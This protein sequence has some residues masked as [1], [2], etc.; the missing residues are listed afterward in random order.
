MNT[1]TL[2]EY[3]V[4][5]GWDIHESDYKHA[6]DVI[7]K[8]GSQIANKISP[9]VKTLG[10]AASF[11]LDVLKVGNKIIEQTIS[12]VADLD[13]ETEKLA[14]QWWVSEEAARSYSTALDALGET[15]EDLATMTDEQYRRLV[16]LNQ[17]G[18]S[19]EAPK[20]LDDFLLI[21]R[22]IKLE[23][24][25]LKV[26]I[27]YGLRWVTYFFAKMNGTDAKNIRERLRSFNEKIQKNLPAI[28][29]KIAEIL[30]VFYRFGKAAFAIGKVL[31][32]L[33]VSIFE[34]FDNKIGK[35]SLLLGSFFLLIKSGPIGWMI[36]ALTSLLLLIDDYMTWQRGGKSYFN[37]SGFDEKFRNIK[38]SLTDIKGDLVGI[39]EQAGNIFDKLAA[40]GAKDAA[41]WLIE[42]AAKGIE[43]SFSG[44]HKILQL[45]SGDFT[46]LG[47]SDDEMYQNFK[48][49]TSA[50][51]G[52]LG[53]A[54]GGVPGALAAVTAVEAGDTV[55]N[56][57]A[58][59]LGFPSVQDYA[60]RDY[61]KEVNAALY[62]N[63]G[64]NMV[65]STNNNNVVSYGGVTFNVKDQYEADSYMQMLERRDFRTP[66]K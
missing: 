7:S 8:F 26:E 30:D 27:Q 55:G 18:R 41:I 51:A 61:S 50:I 66:T 59:K 54:V 4:S 60:G 64:Q 25:K 5:I 11:V 46:D 62:P 43:D 24:A 13:Y 33:I 58:D 37:W 39:F 34:I 32:N 6:T 15:N 2:K 9:N 35:T 12:T 49:I 10:T 44:V 38:D 63:L 31:Y 1:E 17:I 29:K 56:W 53:F 23:F 57:I 47:N 52:V 22:D 16:E 40:M 21:V 48:G 36:T 3:L 42:S 28:A 14:R 65:S 19:L 20:E 45:I